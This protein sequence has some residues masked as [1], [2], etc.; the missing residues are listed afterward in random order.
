MTTRWIMW[1]PAVVITTGYLVVAGAMFGGAIPRV[2]VACGAP[3]LDG[4]FLWTRADAAAFV[5]GCGPDGLEVYAGM[6]RLDL[7]YP[8]LLAATLLCW[9]WLL[10]GGLP[11]WL[12]IALAV[13][14]FAGMVGDYLENAA[15]W[16]MLGAGTV[17]DSALVDAGGVAAAAKNVGGTIAF[18]LVA[19]LVVWRVIRATGCRRRTGADPKD[20]A[21]YRPSGGRRTGTPSSE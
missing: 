8:A 11:G 16:A 14:V 5:S 6:A 19:V 17:P 20:S 15:V 2:A 9:I 7:L 13:P 1:W 21:R 3:P 12:R 10:S 18:A 4:R